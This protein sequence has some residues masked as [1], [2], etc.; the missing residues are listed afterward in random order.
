MENLQMKIALNVI[1]HIGPKLVRRLVS[2]AGSV[3]A[4]FQEKKK[5]L[6][7]IP[8]IGEIKASLFNADT[9]L[10]EAEKE[11]DYIQKEGIKPLFYLD[12]DYPLRLRECEDA[13]VI[14]YT[15]GDV[16]FNV[17]K[18]ISIVG[19]RSATEYG[20]SCTEEIISYLSAQYPYL[21]IVSGLA[22]GIDITAHKVALKYN[23]KTVAALG[24]GFQFIYPALH[25]GYAKKILAQGALVTEF[26]S[27]RKPDPG[28]FVS[29]NRII[30]GISDATVVIE[31]ALKG[32][33]LITADI[34]NSYNRE[35]FALPGRS[36]DTYSNG[37]N[38]L[39]KMNKAGLV[40]SGTDIELA[41]G[42]FN[43]NK[44]KGSIQKSLF[45]QL[46]SLE[47]NILHHLEKQGDSSLDEISLLLK[48]PIA[49]V[50]A[51]LLNLE[52]NGLVKPLPGKYYH[53]I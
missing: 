4:V 1:P 15:K 45:I 40:E 20:K 10:Q 39:I 2:Y 42:W 18:V 26:Q 53:K 43:E 27:D 24:H 11:L 44:K 13:P 52:F 12:N 47:E 7:K 9:L 5:F 6:E 35:V 31:S 30:A 19:T 46:N 14:L 33:A 49:Q 41:M 48:V 29:R 34:A 32:G 22:Y 28:N 50:S 8:G 25:A 3:E 36:I 21:L 51:T 16:D 17:D 23:L 37:C 38:N